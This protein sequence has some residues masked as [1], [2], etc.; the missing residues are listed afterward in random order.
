MQIGF[1][2]DTFNEDVMCAHTVTPGRR[3]KHNNSK[4]LS[5]KFNAVAVTGQIK[6][7]KDHGC[8]L[9][10]VRVCCLKLLKIKKEYIDSLYLSTFRW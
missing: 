7:E 5:K 10:H 3:M 6:T 4:L 2:F 9:L 1:L 8:R